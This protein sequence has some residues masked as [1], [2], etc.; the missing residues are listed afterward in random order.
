MKYHNQC[1]RAELLVTGY[2]VD[3]TGQWFL[4]LSIV[5]TG[6]CVEDGL[7]QIYI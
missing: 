3:C 5:D 1:T 4:D 7:Y 2:G 6:Q